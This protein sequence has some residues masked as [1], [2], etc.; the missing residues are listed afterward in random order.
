MHFSN[1]RISTKLILEKRRVIIIFIIIIITM[2]ITIIIIITFAVITIITNDVWASLL[3][4]FL[5][6]NI[7]SL[8]ASTAAMSLGFDK[9]N[10]AFSIWSKYT[11]RT[12]CNPDWSKFSPHG[13]PRR[14][15]FSGILFHQAFRCIVRC[16]M[17]LHIYMT[18]MI[19]YVIISIT[20]H[21]TS[22]CTACYY[23]SA[24]KTKL[25][26]DALRV[27]QYPGGPTPI[28]S[29]H[30]RH[31]PIKSLKAGNLYLRPDAGWTFTS[32]WTHPDNGPAPANQK[33]QKIQQNKMRHSIPREIPEEKKITKERFWY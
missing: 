15:I 1:L 17:D 20:F 26:V 5:L 12:N 21:Q 24:E 14:C 29:H 19:R 16:C 33:I 11:F 23:M 3:L 18:R 28:K 7:S 2:R 10:F 25:E 9:K 27:I 13:S 4:N 32:L 30:I 31:E 8:A 22:R 6:S